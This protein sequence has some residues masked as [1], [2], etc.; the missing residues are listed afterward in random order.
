MCCASDMRPSLTSMT[1]TLVLAPLWIAQIGTKAKSFRDNPILGSPTLNTWGLYVGRRR[2]AD[3]MG[4][5]RRLKLAK[6]V[7]PEERSRF[8][9][10]GYFLRHEALDASHFAAMRG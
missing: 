9:E 3:A 4:R 5:R 1:R 8:D 7:T 6:H 10:L 2:L